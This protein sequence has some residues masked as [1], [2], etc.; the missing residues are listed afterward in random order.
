VK[1][2]AIQKLQAFNGARLMA[3]DQ[4]T[5]NKRRLGIHGMFIDITTMKAI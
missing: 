2:A 3:L 4:N 1:A 5:V